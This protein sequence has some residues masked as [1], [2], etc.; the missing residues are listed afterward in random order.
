MVCRYR[1]IRTFQITTPSAQSVYNCY[2]F[3]LSS[4]ILFL[5]RGS[6]Q[7]SKAIV[8]PFCKGIAPIPT[9]EASQM[10]SKGPPKVGKAYKG[11][12]EKLMALI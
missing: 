11:V 4:S 6:F 12:C 5:A 3:L 8:C 10:T 2:K 9:M 7:L 1:T